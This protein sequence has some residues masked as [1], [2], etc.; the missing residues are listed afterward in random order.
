[1]EIRQN[2]ASNS[3]RFFAYFIDIVM[4]SI[5]VQIALFL[6]LDDI[7]TDYF[8]E[9]SQNGGRKVYLKQRNLI[10]SISILTWIVYCVFMESSK[11]Q[12]T[13]GK[14]IMGIK[15]VDEN[16]NRM[17]L[18]KSMGRNLSKILSFAVISLGFFWILVD[19]NKQG[20]HDKLNKTFMVNKNFEPNQLI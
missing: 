13:I 7:I 12:G 5:I 3:N 9:E 16:G 4:I 1:M 20:W 6:F 2:L 15:V 18:S 14:S 17:S 11:I 19:D 10:R 8:S